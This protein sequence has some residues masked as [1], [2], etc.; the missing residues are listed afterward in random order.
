VSIISNTSDAGYGSSSNLLNGRKKNTTFPN[1]PSIARFGSVDTDAGTL[2]SATSA[3]TGRKGSIKDRGAVKQGAVP[4][5]VVF[6]P[7]IGNRGIVEQS[8]RR[9]WL[10]HNDSISLLVPL[11]EHGCLVTVSLDGFHRIWNLDK[12][13]LGEFPLPNL[14]ERMKNPR[15]RVVSNTYIHYWHI[16]VVFLSP[17]LSANRA[18]NDDDLQF[19]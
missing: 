4:S 7:P 19:L 6:G 10:G 2:S 12:D 14:L 11:H 17:F 8:S 5:A 15:M 9:E 16:P 18:N 13:C 3:I 1:I